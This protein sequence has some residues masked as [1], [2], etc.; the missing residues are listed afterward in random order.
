MQRGEMLDRLRNGPPKWDVAIIG[1]GATG[2][3]A[4]V[5]AASR[6]YSTVLFEQGD[7]AQAT[8]SRSTKL[9]HGGVRYLRG[10]NI[11]LVHQALRERELLMRNAPG[12]VQPM[13]FVLPSY[14]W[15]ETPF[16]ATG[17]KLY[18]LLA[19]GRSSRPSRIV[20]RRKIL[21]HAPNLCRHRLR[22]GVMFYDAQFDDARLA[23]ALARTAA[24]SGAVVLN[25]CVVSAL[26]KENGRII[27]VAA[28]EWESGEN[29]EIRAHVV[30][31]ATGVFADNIRKMEDAD[32][33][34]MLK[35]SQGI[36]LVVDNSF[37]QGRTAILIPSTDD[38]RVIFAIPWHNRVLIGTTDTPVQKIVLEPKPFSSEI[39]YL[40]D[41]INR[42]LSRKIERS[43]VRSVFAGLRPLVKPAA[44]VR[45]AQIPRDHVIEVS[46]GGMVTITGGKWT[47]Y[48]AMAEEVI[49]K[50]AEYARLPKVPC[51]TAGLRL[52][53]SQMHPV[54]NVGVEAEEWLHKELPYTRRQIVN[55][56]REE[57]PVTIADVLARRTRSLFLDAKASTEIAPRIGRLMAQEQMRDQAWEQQQLSAF[58][59]LARSYMISEIQN[60]CADRPIESSK[61]SAP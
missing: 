12:I 38:R 44:A 23:I 18:D 32:A 48:R 22:G 31:N 41:H 16:Y 10:G 4:A 53:N 47:T 55:A 17:L 33:L 14:K 6:G 30:I 20:P 46:A 15:W 60:D 19:A 36:H 50:A 8:S 27:G 5:D 24:A 37:F 45:T 3:G 9:I 57:V 2:L 40:L 25:Y 28:K 58:N 42:Y 26:I 59:D 52:C 1:G 43:D 49:T 35:P 54:E 7:F 51:K 56:I 34:E 11:P 21:E 39:D 61:G 13:A 29:I